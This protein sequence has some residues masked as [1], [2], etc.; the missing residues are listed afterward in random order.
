MNEQVEYPHYSVTL[1]W[2][3][4]DHIYVVTLPEF[5]GCHTHGA[6][7][8]EAVRNASE[9]IEMLV[10]DARAHGK[11]LPPPRHFKLEKEPVAATA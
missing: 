4:V 7:L 5:G 3:D 6:T 11:P 1:E 8:E 9:V 2:D 10:D